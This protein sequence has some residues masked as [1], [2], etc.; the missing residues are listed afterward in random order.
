MPPRRAA[1]FS[2]LEWASL[3]GH[4][5]DERALIAASFK[6]HLD[7]MR[8]LLERKCSVYDPGEVHVAAASS[9]SVAAMKLIADEH[10]WT[11][12]PRVWEGAAKSGS[13]RALEWLTSTR[14]VGHDEPPPPDTLCVCAATSGDLEAVKWLRSRGHPSIDPDHPKPRNALHK[15]AERGHVAVLRWFKENGSPGHSRGL[16][17]PVWR[18]VIWREVALEALDRCV[19][20]VEASAAL[21]HIIEHAGG[22]GRI[23]LLRRMV[24][25]G[26][27]C[28]AATFASAVKKGRLEAMRWLRDK[29]CPIDKDDIMVVAAEKG[30]V[31]TMAW[32]KDELGCPLAGRACTA[33]VRK[34]HIR[35]VEWLRRNGCPWG[36]DAW[37]A[38]VKGKGG[39]RMRDRLLTNGYRP[40]HRIARERGSWRRKRNARK[41]GRARAV[42]DM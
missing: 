17:Y 9:G 12:S 35:A 30:R 31:G 3:H 25:R 26:Y 13:L 36:A 11:N 22:S 4:V 38:A 16:L 34:G 21:T 19:A 27:P 10:G 33:A 2:A 6:G 29:G 24:S 39:E 18:C 1:R 37:T 5:P 7:A 32:L 42:G 40:P 28:T 14:R 15:V 23:D 41:K 20:E 8:W